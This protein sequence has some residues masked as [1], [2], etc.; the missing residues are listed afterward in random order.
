[1][2]DKTI[3]ECIEE[4]VFQYYLEMDYHQKDT[5]GDSF[6]EDY[7]GQFDKYTKLSKKLRFK[8]QTAVRKEKNAKITTLASVSTRLKDFIE[9][10]GESAYMLLK[11][12][13]E[14]NGLAVNYRN[15]E[16]MTEEEMLNILRQLDLTAFMNELDDSLEDE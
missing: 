1:M 6:E 10:S 15:F 4:G 3:I 13:V 8:A 9:S 2:D 14:N 11:R 16:A 7:E 12:H 5:S